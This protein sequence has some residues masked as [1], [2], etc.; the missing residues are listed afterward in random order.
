M[1][2]LKVLTFEIQLLSIYLT[3]LFD[4]AASI[5]PRRILK[6]KN[7]KWESALSATVP[8]PTGPLFNFHFRC[9]IQSKIPYIS[10]SVFLKAFELV[11]RRASPKKRL[12]ERSATSASQLQF[13]Q[14]IKMILIK[15]QFWR[16]TS[17]TS[18][19]SA[20]VT[21]ERARSACGNSKLE[22]WAVSGN[23]ALLVAAFRGEG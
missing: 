13:S 3:I 23:T 20:I 8:C 18:N 6:K 5:M 9:N 12:S 15:C 2:K 19:C 14:F 1:L 4:Y 22:A 10:F 16:E 21:D 7:L 11:Y 17:M